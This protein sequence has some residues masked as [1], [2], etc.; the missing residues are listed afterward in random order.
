VK[1][2]RLAEEIQTRILNPQPLEPARFETCLLYTSRCHIAG[3]FADD[4]RGCILNDAGAMLIGP[5]RRPHEILRRL[6]DSPDAGVAFARGAEELDNDTRENRRLE[7]RPA[8]V[9]QNNA[10]LTGHAGSTICGRMRD[11]KAHGTF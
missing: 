1:S 8:L 2:G 4:L 6:T 5:V 10:R 3:L 7:K 11:E 9:E